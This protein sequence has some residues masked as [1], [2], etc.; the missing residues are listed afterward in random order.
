MSETNTYFIKQVWR[1]KGDVLFEE[2]PFK[3][4]NKATELSQTTS[5]VLLL[6]T[7]TGGGSGAVFAIGRVKE[8]VVIEKAV[9]YPNGEFLYHVP[10]SYEWIL[11][12]KKSGLTREE[13]QELA[14]QKFA[15][16]AKGGL[17]AIEEGLYL[18]LE[19]LLKE[20][21]AGQATPTEV[22]TPQ[23]QQEKAEAPQ[24]KG[25]TKAKSTA[26]K[27][28]SQGSDNLQ[29]LLQNA[30]QSLLEQPGLRLVIEANHVSYYPVV[31]LESTTDLVALQQNITE[32]VSASDKAG[33][34]QAALEVAAATETATSPRFAN[35]IG[36]VERLV[37]E[38]KYDAVQLP[39]AQKAFYREGKLPNPYHAIE[40]TGAN[41][42]HVLGTDGTLYTVEGK[43]VQ[44]FL[45]L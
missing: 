20:R 14:G 40:L 21:N 33:L 37:R 2:I 17:Y 41:G 43:T 11:E 10:F 36:L 18:Q 31:L 7:K 4:E 26:K 45:G 3:E 23:A 39:T 42:H 29:T 30:H 27:A 13:L 15:P 24:A 35:I 19:A 1:Q 25:E 32:Y 9:E 5:P 12:D 34:D 8:H 6:E 28:H 44:H 22:V 16:Q 38:G